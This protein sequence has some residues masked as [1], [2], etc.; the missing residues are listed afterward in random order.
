MRIVTLTNYG[1][2]SNGGGVKVYTKNLVS[3]IRKKGIKVTLIIR[4]G[5]PVEAEEKLPSNKFIY[6]AKA[7]GRLKKLKPELILSQGGWFTAIPAMIYK[8]QNPDAKVAHI[9]HTH[10]DPPN[11]FIRRILRLTER[12]I[13]TFILSKF[14][15]VFFVSKGLRINVEE[16]GALKVPPNWKIL[17]GAPRV[18]APT[19]EEIEEFTKEFKILPNRFYVL[20]HGLTAFPV[21]AKGAKLLIKAL[22]IFPNN[23]TL[24]LTRRGALVDELK[25]YAEVNNVAE[26][27]IFTGDLENPHTATEVSDVYAHV[28]Y[29]EGG[30]SLA[31]LEVMSI[32]KPIVASKI[33]GIPEAIRH[34]LEGIL[35]KNEKNEIVDALLFLLENPKIRRKMSLISRRAVTKRFSWKKTANKLI[36]SLSKSNDD[37]REY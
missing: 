1:L 25:K 13:M 19:Q 29:G 18:N 4:E 33:G 37:H 32:G 24:I 36:Q 7:T 31:L 12:F 20:A 14:D 28:T 21:K 10:Y 34:P 23:I 2:N 5:V 22:T 6:M 26:R 30:L 15:V 3:V 9:Y 35:V 11:G 27:V 17:Y 16:N 8:L